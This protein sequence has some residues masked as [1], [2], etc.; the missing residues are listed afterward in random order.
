LAHSAPA[1]TTAHDDELQSFYREI[2]A[3]NL[4]PLWESLHDLVTPEPVTPVLPVLWDFDG[5]LRSHL[6]QAG[7]LISAERAERRVLVLENPGLRGTTSAT[8]S[9]YAGVQLVLPGEVARTHR[10]SQ[11]AMRFV[12]ESA[13]ACTTVNGES[14][15]MAPGDFV[16]TPAWTWH[17]HQNDTPEPAMWV[18]VL[19]VPIVSMLDGSFAQMGESDRQVITRAAGDGMA[20]FGHNMLPVDWMPRERYSP[21][22]NYPYSKSREALATLQ[23]SSAPDPCHGYKLRYVN[24]TTG[25]FALPTIG[26]FMQLA[27][28]GWSSQPYRCTDATIFVVV[29]GQGETRIGGVV[30]RWKPRDIFVV[31]GWALHTHHVI[32]EAVLFSASDRPIQT[33]LGLWR[34]ERGGAGGSER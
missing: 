4:A 3:L 12:L 14:I 30:L 24:P 21:I 9:L 11:S 28:S 16:T 23:R 7:K 29:E 5:C 19:D 10:H 31:P 22:F 6:L 20:Q 17:D 2:D 25:D 13:G 26:A 27:P 34:E 1:A 8:H 15:P 18:D 32:E 33:K